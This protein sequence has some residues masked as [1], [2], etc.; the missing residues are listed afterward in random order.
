MATVDV[1]ELI[2]LSMLAV[3]RRTARLSHGHTSVDGCC[4]F[5]RMQHL[6]SRKFTAFHIYRACAAHASLAGYTCKPEVESGFRVTGHGVTGSMILVG[7]GR[8]A[9]KCYWPGVWCICFRFCRRFV[10]FWERNQRMCHP[11]V[12]V[13]L[14]TVIDIS[15][16]LC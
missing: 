16:Y 10:V 1:K 6:V 14:C 4:V 5:V 9:C 8:V 11:W 3:D 7:S 12:C 15:T 13:I 2:L